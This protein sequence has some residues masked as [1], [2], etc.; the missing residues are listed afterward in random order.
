MYA[1]KE[2]HIPASLDK[3]EAAPCRELLSNH[4]TRRKAMQAQT[5]AAIYARNISAFAQDHGIDPVLFCRFATSEGI[6]NLEEAMNRFQNTYAGTW[7]NLEAWAENLFAPGQPGEPDAIPQHLRYYF[8][9][10]TYIRDCELHGYIWT[11]RTNDGI[12]V[13]LSR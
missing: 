1:I 2:S 10:K 11:M 12:A 5:D 8:D 13:F 9:C 7:N 6:D 3:R 4:V